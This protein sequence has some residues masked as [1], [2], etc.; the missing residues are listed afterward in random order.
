MV[1]GGGSVLLEF[2]RKDLKPETISSLATW[3]QFIH[4]DIIYMSLFTDKSTKIEPPSCL[5]N[6]HN[7]S[8]VYP[9]VKTNWNK[10]IRAHTTT[11]NSLIISPD[12]GVVRN[13]LSLNMD[14]SNHLKLVYASNQA[15]G[16]SS[17]IFIL[18]TNSVI[19]S[20]LK[21]VHL[22]IIVEGIL[23][24]QIFDA[25]TELSY[26]YAWDRRNAYEQRVYGVTYAKVSVG[27]LNE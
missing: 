7:S 23:H 26:E 22:K 6:T 1:N 10:Q 9:V 4:M 15:P 2:T 19:P 11:D 18:L 3:N 24:K 17:T 20:N 12:S 8:V 5:F 25:Y 27:G 21:R 16:F 14:D 13:E